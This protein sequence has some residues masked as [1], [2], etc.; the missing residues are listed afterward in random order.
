[1]QPITL[2]TN[3]DKSR[4][5]DAALAKAEI[6]TDAWEV[7]KAY[8]GRAAEWVLFL[9]MIINIIEMLPGITMAGWIMNLV[10]GTQVVMLDIGGLSLSSMAI[11]AREQGDETAAKRA[12]TTS[13]FLIGLM[14][15]TLLLVSVGVLFPAAKPYTDMVEKGLVLVRVVMTV[16]YG[17]VLHALRSSS[18]QAVPVAAIPAVPSAPELEDIVKKTL[19]PI[20][21]QYR[22]EVKAE[23]DAQMK[24]ISVPMIHYQQFA[25][26]LRKEI[27]QP[28]Q[29]P[30]PI[31]A[32][33]GGQG[34]DRETRLAKAYCELLQ[35]G[36]R[37]TGQTLS[38]RARCNRAAALL[39]LKQNGISKESEE[40]EAV[41]RQ[42]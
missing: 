34:A 37:P 11:H 4:W 21:E 3:A 2:P 29:A 35:E 25:V 20:L 7:A 13:R 28:S 17:H 32:G 6:I 16:I 42:A 26:G 30:A 39:W 10:L 5:K 15:I 31:P 36:T 12:G 27:K 40:R 38:S 18:P 1:M 9:C 14:I 22:A 23:M 24:Q 41:S 19:I 33:N 8:A